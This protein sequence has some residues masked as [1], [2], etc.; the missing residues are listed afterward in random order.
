M[1]FYSFLSPTPS[2]I[3]CGHSGVWIQFQPQ[4]WVPSKGTSRL[5][6]RADRPS[7]CEL[8]CAEFTPEI[9]GSFVTR[10]AVT[11]MSAR[12]VRNGSDL[13]SIRIHG[14]PPARP[15]SQ[16]ANLPGSVER[17]ASGFS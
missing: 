6:N 10:A 17:G 8:W 3:A 14:A 15:F 7:L 1:S 9:S 2:N 13:F 4:Q 5:A 12:D 16:P 11:P